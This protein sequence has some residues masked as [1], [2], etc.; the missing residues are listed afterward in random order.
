MNNKVKLGNN[1]INYKT[2]K[3]FIFATLLQIIPALLYCNGYG[4]LPA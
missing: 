4:I 1:V 3:I 2:N